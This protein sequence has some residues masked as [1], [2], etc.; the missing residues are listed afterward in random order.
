M[1]I[2]IEQPKPVFMILGLGI[3]I[4]ISYSVCLGLYEMGGFISRIA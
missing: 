2:K 1:A 3:S 4:I